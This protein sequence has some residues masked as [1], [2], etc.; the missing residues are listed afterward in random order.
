VFLLNPS[1]QLQL[2]ENEIALIS[3]DPYPGELQAPSVFGVAEKTNVTA[4][5]FF[6][7]DADYCDLRDFTGTFPWIYTTKSKAETTQLLGSLPNT[8]PDVQV[9]ATIGK[10]DN[11]ARPVNGTGGGGHGGSPNNSEN[12]NPLG[13]SPSTAVAMIILYSITGIITALFLVIITTG[14]IRAHRH[15]ERYGPRN[16]TGRPRQSRARGLGR[17][18]VDTLPIVKFGERQEPKPADVELADNPSDR[19]QST[20]QDMAGAETTTESTQQNQ[21]EQQS[22]PRESVEGGIAA[23]VNTD[24][25]NTA[26]DKP[27][28]QGCSICTEDFETGQ[29]Q[30]VLPCDHRFHPECID[31]WLLNVSGT[32]PLCR[33]DLRPPTDENAEVD[34]NGNP[35]GREGEANGDLA[36]PLAEAAGQQPRMGIRRSL[37]I[38][39]MGVRGPDRMTQEERVHTARQLRGQHLARIQSDPQ[40]GSAGAEAEAEETQQRRRARLRRVFGIRTRRTGQAEEPV[41]SDEEPESSSRNQ[42]SSR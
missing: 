34:E 1:N 28:N 24:Q 33:I 23:A 19:Q 39:L 14:A 35:V 5:V 42:E 9:Y 26:T 7:Q 29:D 13:P 3:C 18:I 27:E 41:Q 16:V 21:T 37:L 2:T 10:L 36:P 15:P 6:T 20:T 22:Q 25:T 17:A 11:S 32:C 8:N 38:G 4:I 31:P 40:S 12:S 30:R